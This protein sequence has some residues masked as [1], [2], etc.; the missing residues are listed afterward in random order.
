MSETSLPG[1]GTP[2]NLM[3]EIYRHQRFIYDL[4]RK[5]YLLGRDRLIEELQVPDNEPG[6]ATVLEL[7][8][9]TG[10]N[11]ILAARRYPHARLFGIDL[12]EEMLKTARTNIERSGMSDR[13][14]LAQGDASLFNA[15]SLFGETGFGRV[16]FSYALS[17]I[18]P[19]RKALETSLDIVTPGG[20]LHVV[21]F[22]AQEKLPDWFGDLLRVWLAKFHVAPRRD[23][24]AVMANLASA[25]GGELAF[26]ALYR[27]YAQ[28]A[29]IRIPG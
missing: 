13:I 17:M 24:E 5:Y 22:G 23:L 10:R 9:G 7:G 2:S 29:S 15:A 21:D 11:L 14:R 19:W 4:T 6:S 12:S 3:D 26:R 18:P 8:C 28:L 27:D 20:S 1:A 25:H 16:F